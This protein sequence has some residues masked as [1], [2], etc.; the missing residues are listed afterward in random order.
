MH[1]TAL[2]ILRVVYGLFFLAIGLAILVWL[3]TG[4]GSPPTQPNSEAQAFTDA[5]TRS[6]I[7]DPLLAISYAVGGVAL[8]R[9]RTAPLGLVVLAPSIT[10]IALFHLVLSGKWLIGLVVALVFAVLAFACRRR[11]SALWTA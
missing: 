11:L 2:R 4:L 10:V 1:A 5:L 3:L 6:R 9:E 8:L 7:I